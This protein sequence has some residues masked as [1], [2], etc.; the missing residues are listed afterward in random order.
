[1][2][3]KQFIHWGSLSFR[4]KTVKIIDRIR[5]LLGTHYQCKCGAIVRNVYKQD[6]E[7]L[8]EELKKFFSLST[9]EEIER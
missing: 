5:L 1:M 7:F 4:S 6:H 8:H 9:R 2:I 3:K